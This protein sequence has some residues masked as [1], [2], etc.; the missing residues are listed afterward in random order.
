MPTASFEQILSIALAQQQKPSQP[1][2]VPPQSDTVE[3]HFLA[4]TPNELSGYCT[5][6]Q[7]MQNNG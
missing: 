4:T 2:P 1:P 7:Y 5:V 6:W 3:L